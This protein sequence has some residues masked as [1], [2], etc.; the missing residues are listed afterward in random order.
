[1][2][3]R[4][5][6]SKISNICVRTTSDIRHF[7]HLWYFWHVCPYNIRHPAF[8]WEAYLLDV[9][10]TSDIFVWGSSRMIRTSFFSFFK[11]KRRKRMVRSSYKFLRQK[12][13]MSDVV[14]ISGKFF[15]L[16]VRHPYNVRTTSAR[17]RTDI[18]R[19]VRKVSDCTWV[20]RTTFFRRS[21]DQ[22]GPSGRPSVEWM[23]AENKLYTRQNL[24]IKKC[25]TPTIWAHNS[26]PL[27]FMG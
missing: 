21:S 9:R 4:H 19:L 11:L 12:F 13:R 14:R 3:I 22:K 27:Y 8:V 7:W 6:T 24:I 26:T 1:M 17:R 20:S 10:T 25:F 23:P 2:S 16:S 5:P 18:L 15:M